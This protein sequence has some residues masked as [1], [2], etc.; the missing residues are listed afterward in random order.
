MKNEI[1]ETFPR[2]I[3]RT[4][5]QYIHF[6]KRRSCTKNLVRFGIE[7][8]FFFFFY[9]ILIKS[10]GAAKGGD[11]R[12]DNSAV[13]VDFVRKAEE[14]ENLP[15]YEDAFSANNEMISSDMRD[16]RLREEWE[17]DLGRE[18]E[19]EQKRINVIQAV[20]I[21][22]RK[23]EQ[24]R[25]RVRKIR[26]QRKKMIEKRLEQLKKKVVREARQKAIENSTRRI[27]DFS[28]KDQTVDKNEEDDE[29]VEDDE[30]LSKRRKP[31]G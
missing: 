16:K 13:L 2:S 7:R 3:K 26:K 9:L 29:D 6:N 25:N 17:H 21:E 5:I 23:T 28:I 10:H 31:D 18:L 15:D 20:E 11:E 24:A 14:E 4:K 1:C 8:I 12:A 19:Q 30:D 22:A 27:E